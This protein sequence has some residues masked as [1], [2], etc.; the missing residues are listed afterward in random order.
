M[1]F[2]IALLGL[3]SCVDDSGM[4]PAPFPSDPNV[5]LDAPGNTVDLQAFL[6]SKLDA[7]QIDDAEAYE[8]SRS[9]EIT[10]PPLGY[11]NG[12]Y[13]G[14][15]IVAGI[16]RNLTEYDALTFWAKAAKSATLD[17]VGI[18]NDNTGTSKYTAE[19]KNLPLTTSWQQFII[20]IPDA[21]RLI[22]ERGLFYYAEG[23]ENG[24]GNIIHFDEIKFE[25]L[26]TIIN[27]RPVLTPKVVEVEIGQTIAL[28]N[29]LVTFDINGTDAD[30][31][32][33]PGYF[34]FSSSNSSAVVV[35]SDGTVTAVGG[36]T[37]ELTASLGNVEASGSITVNVIAPYPL[38]TVPAP[39]PTVD[40]ADVVSLYSDAYTSAN[41]DLWSTDW[42]D[43]QVEDFL[44]GSDNIKKYFD[45]VFAGIDFSSET[46]DASSTTR[47]HMDVWTP[48]STDAPA[49]FKIKLV[50][51]GP[52]GIF[53]GGDDVEHE[54]VLDHN[55]M[56]TGEWVSI[57]VPLAL[58]SNLTTTGNLAQMILSGDLSVVYVDNIYFYD[59]GIQVEPMTSAP[60]PSEDPSD[61]VSIY[62]DH[63]TSSGVN[64]WSAIWDQ[65]D[66]EDFVLN[67]DNI[68]NIQTLV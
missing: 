51:F 21:S 49:V 6:G 58:F 35:G 24:E 28:E 5:F 22:E 55:T 9:I 39:T 26:G 43:T 45:L 40:A 47:F 42:D 7:L 32:A 14:G 16:A 34:T 25:T 59:A 41:V 65:A 18:G 12:S 53:E 23:P 60:T 10:V 38:P 61:V 4:E 52:N 56:K 67:T 2:C 11:P 17:V 13:A 48:V 50:D 33:M 57:D 62:S 3:I 20:P 54:I 37:A 1:V 68:K 46:L 64:T 44:I 63:F 27:P 66:V 30:V 29:L 8:G 31:S 19:V 36:G 15:A